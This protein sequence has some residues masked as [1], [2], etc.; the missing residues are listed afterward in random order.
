VVDPPRRPCAGGWRGASPL[1]VIAPVSSR[2]F[3]G[4]TG[5]TGQLI[6]GATYDVVALTLATGLAVYKP[7]RTFKHIRRDMI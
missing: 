5:A 3:D 6:A 7:G 4:E 1:F 2:L